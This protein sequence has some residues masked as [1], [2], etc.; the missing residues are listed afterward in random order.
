MKI[1]S[2]KNVFEQ[3]RVYIKIGT[4]TKFLSKR[5]Y[6]RKSANDNVFEQA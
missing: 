2:D 1:G 5:E 4:V 3:A 6:S